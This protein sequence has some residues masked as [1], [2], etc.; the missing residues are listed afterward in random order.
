[1]GRILLLKAKVCAEPAGEPG[2]D[3]IITT[4]K[5]VQGLGAA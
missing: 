5:I 3:Q 1:M 4:A 2:T